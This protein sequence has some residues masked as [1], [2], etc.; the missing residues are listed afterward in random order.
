M[1]TENLPFTMYPKICELEAHHGV[2]IGTSYINE[3]AGNEMI[4]Y[5]AESR[6]QELM[7]KL[8]NAKFFS[9]LLDGSTDTANID[10]EVIL[11]VWCDRDGRDEKVHTRMEYF[12]VVRPQSVTAEGLLK[13]LES[14]L[15]VLGINEISAENCKK[16]VGI[17]TDGASANIAALGLKVL[18]ERRLSWVFW[19]W[20]M[21]HRLELAIKDAMK[22]TAFD[23]IDDLLLRLYYLYEKSPK[24]CRELEDIIT[25][26]KECLTFDDAGI[27]PVRASGSRWVAHKLNAMKRVV[28]KFGAYTNHI[29]ALS[30]DRSVKSA[31][32]AK[33]KGYYS[34]WTQAKYLFGCALFVDLLTPCAIFSKCMQS[35]EVDILGALTGLLKTLKETDKLASKP[36][37]QWPTYAATLRKCTEEEGHT[38]YQCQNLKSYSEAQSY[39]SSKYK[40]YC[41]NVS[42]CIKSR[43]SW[44]DLQLMRDIIFVLSSHGWEKLIEEE[45]NLAAIDRLIER[46]EIPLQG[47]QAQM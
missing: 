46:F 3:N 1:A 24:K 41:S 15:Q 47:A 38:V 23:L 36:L 2:C 4:H 16:L 14:G 39:Y 10:N 32:R 19:M 18:V 35:D 7:K 37:D 25:D 44:S 31:D 26:L 34:K 17:G 13:V 43:L 28:S 29:A 22:A 5:I 9:L 45:D 30:E 6:R 33:L 11:A 20:C 8:A 12:T 42:Q 21:A 27:K 40:E